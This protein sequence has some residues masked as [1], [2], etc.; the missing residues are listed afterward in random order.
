MNFA[1]LVHRH[2]HPDKSLVSQQIWT[3]APK[4][5]RWINLTQQ[6]KQICVMDQASAINIRCKILD[7]DRCI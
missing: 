6:R 2:V 3:F 4:A 5:Q 1:L 7:L